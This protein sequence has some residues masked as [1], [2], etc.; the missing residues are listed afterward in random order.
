MAAAVTFAFILPRLPT[1]T[2]GT[3]K[4]VEAPTC[5]SPGRWSEKEEWGEYCEEVKGGR[6]KQLKAT[7]E[8]AGVLPVIGCAWNVRVLRDQHCMNWVGLL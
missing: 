6:E 7:R 3:R 5:M 8:A 4:G 2:D 1:G